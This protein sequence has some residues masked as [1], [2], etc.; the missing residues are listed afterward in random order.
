MMLAVI[1]DT[2][3]TGCEIRHLMPKDCAPIF[4]YIGKHQV[5]KTW[6]KKLA[7]IIVPGNVQCLRMVL[8]PTTLQKK[9]KSKFFAS[10]AL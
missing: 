10:E 1:V 4:K 2:E 3:N 5:D 8:W 6:T 7:K 9:K